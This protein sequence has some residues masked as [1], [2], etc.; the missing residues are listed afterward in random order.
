MLQIENKRNAFSFRDD[1]KDNG[2]GS[3]K[4]IDGTINNPINLDNTPI[5]LVVES[6]EEEDDV[7]LTADEGQDEKG[8]GSAHDANTDSIN[9]VNWTPDVK[10]QQEKNL[11]GNSESDKEN[12]NDCKADPEV[13]GKKAPIS[14]R[15]RQDA[16]VEKTEASNDRKRNRVQSKENVLKKHVM[17]ED[18]VE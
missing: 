18:N 8:N 5:Q 7:Y 17:L 12:D 11:D 4:S 3:K 6:S 14:Q 15:A 13:E 9:D 1:I 10:E 2:K 16:T